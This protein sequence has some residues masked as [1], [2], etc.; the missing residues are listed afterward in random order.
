M[1]G[2]DR[3]WAARYNAGEV[4]QYT[5]GSK[6]EGIERGSFA[7]VRS[8][9]VY[10]EEERDLAVGERIQFTAPDR[11]NRIRSGDFAT[12][13]RIGYDNALSVRFDNGNKQQRR[14]D[15]HRENS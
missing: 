14:R 4:L 2:V 6:A 13:E 9:D 8:V 3:T 1:T 10:R 11:E 5:T 15:C 7:T 12:V